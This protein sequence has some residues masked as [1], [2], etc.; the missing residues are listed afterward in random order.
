[1][2]KGFTLIELLATIVVI[3]LVALI[4]FPVVRGI[5]EKTKLKALE[6]SAYGL[7]QASNL[8]YAQYANENTV[9]FDKNEEENTLKNL[10]YKG[11]VKT[12]TVLI[13]KKG[14]V[15]VCINDGKNSAYKNY[16]ETKVTAVASK[17]CTV[18]SNTYIVYLDNEKTIKEYTNEELTELVDQLKSTVSSLKQEVINDIYPVG[19][20]YMSMENTNPSTLF[21]G[22]WESIESGRMLQSTSTVSG[23]IGGQTSIS[24][25][26]SGSVN[27]HQLTVNEMPSHAHS[28]SLVYDD[29]STINGNIQFSQATPIG[30][31][32]Y[33]I[34]YDGSKTMFGLSATSY[35]G[36]SQSHSHTF[37][38]TQASIATMPPYITVYMWKRTA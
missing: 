9:R 27:G 30:A 11:E 12:G 28:V 15:T 16:S 33:H 34:G 23:T 18:P 31:A 2:K 10:M 3:A 20:I 17:T 8:Y 14:Q 13:N 24:Y 35:N 5:I 4:A 36:A 1:M 25:T 26:P 21:G 19:S 29:G 22:T 6:D 38:G 7:V 37:T 32:T